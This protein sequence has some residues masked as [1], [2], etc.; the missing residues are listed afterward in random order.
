MEKLNFIKSS[1]LADFLDVG[2]S[3]ISSVKHG[4]KKFSVSQ[5]QK[6]HAKYGVP[7]TDLR[8]DVYPAHLFEVN[9]L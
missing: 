4:R 8:P 3:F 1:E 7:L 5:A 9:K 2:R 6:I